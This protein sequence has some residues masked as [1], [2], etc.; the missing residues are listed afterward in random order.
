MGSGERGSAVGNEAVVPQAVGDYDLRGP[1]FETLLV[2][3]ITG[4][5]IDADRLVRSGPDGWAN[6]FPNWTMYRCALAGDDHLRER[7]RLWCVAFAIAYLADAPGSRVRATDELGALLG[8]DAYS[9]LLTTRWLATG[10]DVDDV[11]GVSAKTYRRHRDRIFRRLR[12]S[13][14]EYWVRL[15]IGMRQAALLERRQESPAP[16]VRLADGR[17]FDDRVD[18]T[19]EG[20]FR[21][22][23]RGSGC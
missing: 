13:L 21:A 22:M 18:P 3:P 15:Q 7:L 23:P 17:G 1:D 2:G 10:E 5:I 4:T 6:G 14:D 16:I 20:N 12:A 8:W 11:A 19:G 9:A